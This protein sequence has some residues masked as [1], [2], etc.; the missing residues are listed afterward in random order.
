MNLSQLV[1][2]VYALG[3]NFVQTADDPTNPANVA[4]N[5]VYR[6]VCGRERWPFLEKTASAGS[7]VAAVNT[8]PL[9]TLTDLRQVDAIRLT[10]S[11]GVNY[12]LRN[13]APQD[14]KAQTFEA[15]SLP[16]TTGLPV[17]WTQY[18]GSILF[19]PPPDGVYTIVVDYIVQPAALVSLTDVPIIPTQW[20]DILVWGAAHELAFRERDWIGRNDSL[21]T[22]TQRLA[23]MSSEYRLMQRQTSS[24]VQQ[25]GVNDSF[26]YGIFQ[27]GEGS[28]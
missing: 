10:D 19:F 17:C 9:S 16:I 3:Y 15:T 21:N 24:R 7:T 28:A 26:D 13:M 6:D 18:A 20:H 12:D 14:F 22:F 23:N 25:S 2:S 4:L 5:S 11:S 1:N 27:L 8:Y